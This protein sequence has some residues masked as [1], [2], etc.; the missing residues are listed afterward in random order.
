MVS[1]SHEAM[2]RIIQENPL[3]PARTFKRL[4]YAFA[5][6][7]EVTVLPTDLTE[8]RPLERRVDTLLQCDVKGGRGYLLAVESQRRKDPD[9]HGSWAFY[10][11]YLYE[12]YRKPPVLVVVCSD[13]G[14][15]R[16]ASAP[17]H[18]GVP[19][20]RDRSPAGRQR[21][22]RRLQRFHRSRLG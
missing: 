3:M 20:W 8:I 13:E 18:L 16:W 21:N 2:H 5:E 14:T 1:S 12:K 19:K 11:S 7:Y 10:L 9:K 6:P 17:F 22:G 15:A 4:G